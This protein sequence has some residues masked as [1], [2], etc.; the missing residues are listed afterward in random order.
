MAGQ[1]STLEFGVDGLTISALTAGPQ[2]SAGRPLIAA[3]HGGTYKAQYF[4]VAGSDHGSFLD[5][6]SGLGYSVMSFD[7]PGYGASSVLEPDDNT[8]ARHTQLLAGAIAQAAA[9]SGADGVVL[10]GHSI[11]GMIAAMI[12]AADTDFRLL[13]LSVTGMGAVIRGGDLAPYLVGIGTITALVL[14]I[15]VGMTLVPYVILR[16]G[17]FWR[18]LATLASLIPLM[19]Y[20]SLSNAPSILKTVF[21]ASETWKRTPKTT[22]FLEGLPAT[23]QL[24]EAG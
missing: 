2:S 5:L 19:I 6:A 21:G 13:G 17:S 4:D 7:R 18:Y 1:R 12:A 3:L 9:G 22:P 20:V 24:N 15:G 11:G 8:F 23:D 16:R 14:I 10:V